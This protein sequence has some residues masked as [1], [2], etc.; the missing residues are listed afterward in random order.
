[1]NRAAFISIIERNKRIVEAY[2]QGSPSVAVA[3]Q[4][5]MGKSQVRDILRLY[6]V[7]RSVGRPRR[8]A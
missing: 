8:A 4:F 6:G 3:Q 5:G 1:M 2:Q 7:S